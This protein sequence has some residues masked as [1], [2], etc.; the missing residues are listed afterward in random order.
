MYISMIELLAL[1]EQAKENAISEKDKQFVS[2][3][4]SY[5][6]LERPALTAKQLMYLKGLAGQITAKEVEIRDSSQLHN[7]IKRFSTVNNRT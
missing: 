2:N 4:R 3:V 6:S 1:Y 7:N 5:L